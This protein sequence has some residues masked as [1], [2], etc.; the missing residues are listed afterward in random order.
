M[1]FTDE[2]FRGVMLIQLNGAHR[3]APLVRCGVCSQ[4]KLRVFTTAAT[5]AVAPSLPVS[6][7]VCINTKWIGSVP[8][9]SAGASAW[10][11]TAIMDASRAP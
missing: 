4:P 3:S 7:D 6:D 2:T 8:C 11:M 5:R 10:V 1:A 9:P